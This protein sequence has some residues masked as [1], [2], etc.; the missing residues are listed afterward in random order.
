[1]KMED[2]AADEGIMVSSTP[3]TSPPSY[4]VGEMTAGAG[5]ASDSVT[6]RSRDKAHVNPAPHDTSRSSPSARWHMLYHTP[7][8]SA[9]KVAPAPGLVLKWASPVGGAVMSRRSIQHTITPPPKRGK[10]SLLQPHASSI[11][12]VN[13]PFNSFFAQLIPRLLQASAWVTV[14]LFGVLYLA[15]ITFFAMIYYALGA[16]CFTFSSDSAE[17]GF[18]RV[19]WLSVHTFSTIGYGTSVPDCTAAEVLV[20]LESYVAL[21]LTFWFSGFTIFFAMRPRSRVRFSKNYLLSTENDELLLYVRMVRESPHA[22]R[23]ARATVQAVLVE[24]QTDGSA[25]ERCV[26]LKL[27]AS[28]KSSLDQWTLCH[29]I[30]AGSPLWEIRTQLASKLTGIDVS[31]CVYDTAYMQEMRLYAS[32]ASN[33]FVQRAHF[34]PMIKLVANPRGPVRGGAATLFVV[35]A[36]RSHL[37]QLS[38][39]PLLEIITSSGTTPARHHAQSHRHHMPTATLAPPAPHAHHH[40]LATATHAHHHAGPRQARRLQPRRHLTTRPQAWPCLCRRPPPQCQ[41]EQFWDRSSPL[42][43]EFIE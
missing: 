12:M 16:E 2:V 10:S 27:V 17:W 8:S 4:E 5:P 23:D 38:H 32:Y 25:M 22:L 21:L 30:V 33:E 41:P 43:L 9:G 6:S 36:T 7:G 37:A 39:S 14:V 1:M 26:E 3:A 18:R 13:P 19:L 24:E 15:S 20:L 34:A 42:W 28:T 40:A 31:L 29:Q 11:R 35:R